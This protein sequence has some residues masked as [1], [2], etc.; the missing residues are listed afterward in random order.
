V[1]RGTAPW[2]AFLSSKLMQLVVNCVKKKEGKV[3]KGERGHGAGNQQGGR[4]LQLIIKTNPRLE[5]R[6]ESVLRA[7]SIEGGEGEVRGGKGG[8][9]VVEQ[10]GKLNSLNRP[11][12]YIKVFLNDSSTQGG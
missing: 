12:P 10:K 6:I 11:T 2:R 5:K 4:G 8:R 1:R 9:R 7:E 3:W